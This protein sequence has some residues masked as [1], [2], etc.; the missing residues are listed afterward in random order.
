MNLAA[1][2][3]PL[4]ARRATKKVGFWKTQKSFLIICFPAAAPR[5][6]I[7]CA[8]NLKPAVDSGKKNGVK[9][10]PHVKYLRRFFQRRYILF[11][12]DRTLWYLMRELYRRPKIHDAPLQKISR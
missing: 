2:V 5:L 1:A 7:P 8:S 3:D 10:S 6:S 11:R 9:N 4:Q 12:H